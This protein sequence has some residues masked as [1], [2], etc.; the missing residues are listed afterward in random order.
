MNIT[1][2]D[3]KL[4]KSDREEIKN[5]KACTI[6]MSGLSGSGKS[7]IA[8]NLECALHSFGNHTYILDGDN[9]RLGINKNLGFTSSDRTENIRR[10]AEISKLM[11]DA[12]LIVIVAAISPF[13]KDRDFARSLFEK[14]EFYEIFVNTPLKVC[15]KRDPKNLYKK[16]RSIKGFSKIGLTGSYEAPNHPDIMIDTSKEILSN[17]INKIVKEITIL[18]KK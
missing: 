13:K 14:N 12:G 5:Q 1:K 18:L 11:V 15:I 17:S 7:T 8:N 6:W 10:I 3:F 4:S 16:S 2:H 9:L